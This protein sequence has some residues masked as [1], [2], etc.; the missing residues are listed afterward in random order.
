MS[1]ATADSR[2]GRGQ[3]R[4]WLEHPPWRAL[5]PAPEPLP[6]SLPVR[7]FPGLFFFALGLPPPWEE[8][9]ASLF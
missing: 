1:P 8:N 5:Q 2:A 4:W 9:L 3:Q 7:G 6:A